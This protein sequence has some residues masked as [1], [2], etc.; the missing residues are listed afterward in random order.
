MSKEKIKAIT[1]ME[2]KYEAERKDQQN[3]LL[4]KEHALQVETNKNQKLI[5]ASIAVIIVMASFV[6]YLRAI[7][8]KQKNILLSENLNTQNRELMTKG[9]L[10]D[11]KNKAFTDLKSWLQVAARENRDDLSTSLKSVIKEIDHQIDFDQDWEKFKFHFEKIHP[12]FFTKLKQLAPSLSMTELKLCSY[13]R[14][15]LSTKEIAKLTNT[16]IRSVQ[17]AKYRV[18]QKL[19]PHGES[20][21]VDYIVK[22]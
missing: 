15:N 7:V 21:L 16:T 19:S 11:K 4:V 2:S 22:L 13:L 12:D 1:E 8:A 10:V 20:N 5:F 6:F 17:Q 9:L 14:L 18:N 3:Q